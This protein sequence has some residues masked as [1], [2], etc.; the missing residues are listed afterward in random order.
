MT[1]YV[2]YLTYDEYKDLGGR[3]DSAA[4]PIFER[5]AQRILDCRTFNR[6]DPD[7]VSAEVKE[8]LVEII[9]LLFKDANAGEEVSSFSN[10]VVSYSFDN[11]KKKSAQQEIDELIDLYLPVE[12]IS[13]VVRC[14]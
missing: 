11:S 13:G 1:E 4:F 3:V 5:K 10:G 7:N 8:V 6:I 9:N 12:L 2:S 14:E